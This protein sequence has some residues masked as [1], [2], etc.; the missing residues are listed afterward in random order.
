MLNRTE[1]NHEKIEQGKTKHETPRNINHNATQNK[2]NTSTTALEQSVAKA[3]ECLKHLFCRQIFTLGP[4]I[5]LDAKI[6]KGLAR[7]I[8]N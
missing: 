3:T 4:D 1:T 5:I 8:A 2:N 7:I 6:I